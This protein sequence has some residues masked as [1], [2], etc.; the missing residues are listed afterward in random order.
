MSAY[1]DPGSR[2]NWYDPAQSKKPAHANGADTGTPLKLQPFEM[3]AAPDWA[4]KPAPDWL[5]PGFLLEKSLAIVYGESGSGKSFLMSFAAHVLTGGCGWQDDWVERG[6]VVYFATENPGSLAP[7]FK[8]M[9]SNMDGDFQGL[10]IVPGEINLLD[11]EVLSRMRVTIRL[12]EYKTGLPVRLVI[13]DTFRDGWTGNEDASQDVAKAF[14]PLKA[15]RNQ[16]NATVCLVHHSGHAGDRERGSSHIRANVDTAW[17]VSDNDGV[18][19]V[20]C[21]K[22]RDCAKP[23]SFGFELK[24]TPDGGCYVELC[25]PQENT[26]RKRPRPL[27]DQHKLA[28]NAL[29][30]ALA[31]GSEPL[32]QH[33]GFSASIRAARCDAWRS[34]LYSTLGDMDQ[35]AKRQAYNRSMGALQAKEIIG[36]KDDWVW[37]INDHA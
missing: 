35:A 4:K 13:V 16:F 5:L 19:T 1:F 21:K 7:R 32:P 27:S 25:E 34:E 10:M 12:A 33:L 3:V 26:P 24:G 2:G 31:L 20:E 14:A 23:E 11:P 30:N 22:M 29:K 17:Q 28:L 9:Q 15:I 6:C 18:R 37:L 36:V 8:A